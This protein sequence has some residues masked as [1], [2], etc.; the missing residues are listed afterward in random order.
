MNLTDRQIDMMRADAQALGLSGADLITNN[1]NALIRR[2]C[3]GIGPSSFPAK[4]REV[5][6]RLLPHILLPSIIHDLRYY[7]GTG[8][9]DDFAAANAELAFNAERVAWHG[10]AWWRV[11]RKLLVLWAGAR[12]ASACDRFGWTAYCAAIRERWEAED[13]LLLA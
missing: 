5:L 4:A 8:S 13:A 7:Y 3:N 1:S 2:V 11:L 12:C 6:D 10:I 9:Y